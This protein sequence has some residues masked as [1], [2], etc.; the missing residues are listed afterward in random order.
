MCCLFT[1]FHSYVFQSEDNPADGHSVTPK[2]YYIFFHILNCWF[3]DIYNQ[4]A[5]SFSYFLLLIG[6]PEDGITDRNV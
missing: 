6:L 1:L 2:I 3:C 4:K 5:C